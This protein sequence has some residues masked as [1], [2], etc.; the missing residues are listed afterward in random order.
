MQHLT[1]ELEKVKGAPREMANPEEL[2]RTQGAL[3]AAMAKLTDTENQLETKDAMMKELV[4]TLEETRE[5]LAR[6]RSYVAQAFDNDEELIRIKDELQ[7]AEE[8]SKELE[9]EISSLNQI[10]EDS[11]AKPNHQTEETDKIVSEKVV[12][13]AALAKQLEA[14]KE[15]IHDA[16]G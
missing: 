3:D 10:I 2:L 8:R 4:K 13:I 6:E 11:K 5:E 1:G 9:K 15:E 12:E 14:A 7:K 16:K